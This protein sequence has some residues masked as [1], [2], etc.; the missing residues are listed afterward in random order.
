V[1]VGRPPEASELAGA[2]GR[3]L[4]TLTRG[5][6]ERRLYCV[7][8]AGGGASAFSGWRRAA[9]P[10]VELM[11]V[12]LPGRETLFRHPPLVDLRA[13][14]RHLACLIAAEADRTPYAVLGHCS[15]ALLAFEAIRRLARA[16]APLPARLFVAARAAPSIAPRV[17]L[18]DLPE[19][20]LVAAVRGIGGTDGTVFDNPGLRA[21]YVPPLRADFAMAERYRLP[22]PVRIPVPIT[23]FIGRS[24]PMVST[25]EA[26]AWRHFTAGA[27]RMRPLDGGHFLADADAPDVLA[28]V[29]EAVRD[30]VRDAS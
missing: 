13:A 15:G 30:A 14:A 27:F 23:A 29:R 25:E 8:G 19:D 28:Q 20:E 4:V 9:A 22:R 26:D 12:R 10:D 3:W 11:A 1:R 2:A 17:M 24:D 16:G 7:P 21:A 6:G 18:A 5:E